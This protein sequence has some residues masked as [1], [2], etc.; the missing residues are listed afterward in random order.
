VLFPSTRFHVNTNRRS[1]VHAEGVHGGHVGEQHTH[2]GARAP[3]K[4]H[5]RLTT[6][7]GDKSRD[8]LVWEK[9]TQAD[10]EDVANGHGIPRQNACLSAKDPWR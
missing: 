7:A 9:G 1:P 5:A 3:G 10:A 2:T 8:E 4:L 6:L